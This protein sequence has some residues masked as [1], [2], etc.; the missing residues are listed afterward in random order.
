MVR[1]KPKPVNLEAAQAARG[2]GLS[3][4]ET[5]QILGVS[6]SAVYY[7][8]NPGSRGASRH[9]KQRSIYTTDEVWD[10]VSQLAW[11]DGVSVSSVVADILTGRRP[12]VAGEEAGA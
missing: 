2:R 4:A 11:A 7:A 6:P 12:P 5:A 3:Y 10:R 1:K 8:L 9:G